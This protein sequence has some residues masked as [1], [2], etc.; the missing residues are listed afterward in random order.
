ML[1]YFS[2]GD[3]EY[4]LLSAKKFNIINIILIIC[5]ASSGISIILSIFFSYLITRAFVQYSDFINFLK[6]KIFLLEI[7]AHL[8]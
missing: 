6:V 8:A 5:I 2:C 1:L 3:K 4:K 7:D